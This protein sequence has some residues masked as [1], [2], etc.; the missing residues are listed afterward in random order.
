[1]AYPHEPET[2]RIVDRGG[3]VVKSMREYL[4]YPD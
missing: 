4:S 1:M 3:R 2:G